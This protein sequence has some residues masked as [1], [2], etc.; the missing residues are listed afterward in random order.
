MECICVTRC[1]HVSVTGS[2]FARVQHS[3]GLTFQKWSLQ[4]KPNIQ[5]I[6]PTIHTLWI[7]I[8]IINIPVTFVLKSKLSWLWIFLMVELLYLYMHRIRYLVLLEIRVAWLVYLDSRSSGM[9]AWID[10]IFFNTTLIFD[11]CFDIVSLLVNHSFLLFIWWWF[12][13]SIW[14]K[15]SC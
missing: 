13:W 12:A 2:L 11:L 7:R 1:F 6:L 15:R 8:N 4:I 14:I 10:L 3:F 5:K 9:K